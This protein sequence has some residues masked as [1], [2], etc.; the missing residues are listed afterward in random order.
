MTNTDEIRQQMEPLKDDVLISILR[1]HDESQ[2]RPEVFDIVAAILKKRGISAGEGLECSAVE[3]EDSDESAGFDLITVAEYSTYIDA[4]TDRLALE[5][6]GVKAWINNEDNPLEGVSSS[7]QI[8]VRAGDLN[9]A[10]QILEAEPVPSSELPADIAEPPCPQCGSRKVT[11]MAE[12]VEVASDSGSP[13]QRQ[14]WLYNCSSCGHK[15][16]EQ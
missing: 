10:M 7:V 13:L 14:E 15:W 5:A 3:E 12:I 9:A 2:W 4:E 16:P 8:Q 1:E 6:E 11:E